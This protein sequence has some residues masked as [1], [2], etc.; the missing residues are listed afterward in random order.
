[1]IYLEKTFLWHPLESSILV[2]GCVNGQLVI[3]DICDH[4]ESLKKNECIWDHSVFL[5]PTADRWTAEI[6]L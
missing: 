5:S 2:G 3:W 6:G 1:M 4:I